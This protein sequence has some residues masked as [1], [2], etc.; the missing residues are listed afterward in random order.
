M[1]AENYGKDSREFCVARFRTV[2]AMRICTAPFTSAGSMRAICLRGPKMFRSE[3]DPQAMK[4]RVP[5]PPEG[6]PA[7]DYGVTFSNCSPGLGFRSPRPTI[8]TL[9]FRSVS[10][11]GRFSSSRIL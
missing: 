10:A 8:Q 5:G 4:G 9:A 3:R 7:L 2:R 1:V 11:A 6:A